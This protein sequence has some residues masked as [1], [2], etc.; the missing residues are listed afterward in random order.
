[1]SDSEDEFEE[2]VQLFGIDITSAFRKNRD[3]FK[4][5]NIRIEPIE[6]EDS[7]RDGEAEVEDALMGDW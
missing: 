7:A 5:F 4:A 3:E 2:M 1:M 6:K